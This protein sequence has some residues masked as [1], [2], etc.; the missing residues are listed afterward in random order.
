MSNTSSID[1]IVITDMDNDMDNEF[2]FKNV[3]DFKKFVYKNLCQCLGQCLDLKEKEFIIQEKRTVCNEIINTLG[4]T[5]TDK[6]Y[7][8]YDIIILNSIEFFKKSG[9][10]DNDNIEKKY[11]IINDGIKLK[12]SWANIKSIKNNDTKSL[13]WLFRKL[14]VDIIL[15]KLLLDYTNIK[16]YSVGSTTLSSDYDITVYN[17]NGNDNDNDI[18]HFI[19]DFETMFNNIF[20]DT[21]DIVFDTNIY[22]KSFITFM[23]RENYNLKECDGIKT[24]YY[25]KESDTYNY[26]QLTW[27]LIKYFKNIKESFDEYISED[28]ITFLSKHIRSRNVNLIKIANDTLLTLLNKNLN[29]NILLQNE[30]EFKTIYNNNDPL[31]TETDYISAVNFYG[32][33]TYFTKGA[34]I[35]IVINDQ[36]CKSEGQN[37][38]QLSETDLICSILENTGFYF[39]H[40]N[41][42]KYLKRVI[43]TLNNLI[44]TNPLRYESLTNTTNY[45]EFN[46][47]IKTLKTDDKLDDS[48][49]CIWIDNDKDD[50]DLLK[51]E[52]Y[53]LFNL[54]FH[55]IYILLKINIGGLTIH[56]NRIPFYSYFINKQTNKK[57]LD[58]LQSN[59]NVSSRRSSLDNDI[60]NRTSSLNDNKYHRRSSLDDNYNNLRHSLTTIAENI[61]AEP[62]LK[63]TKEIRNL[64]KIGGGKEIPDWMLPPSKS[65]IMYE[66]LKQYILPNLEIEK[67]RQKAKNEKILLKQKW[68]QEILQQ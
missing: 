2:S 47:I 38:I 55:I 58:L 30:K 33:E 49:Y 29:Y 40:S 5:D 24:F 25:L 53:T 34:F 57:Y 48:K 52:K 36:M 39:V 7:D 26:S 23:K 64:N 35:D 9:L 28:Y 59:S 42:T 31:L 11:Y 43:S 44:S 8:Y 13:F 63:K 56:H 4:D 27:A 6:A 67:K 20:N 62:S 60:L 65:R 3:T 15:K 41:K 17:V 61:A 45:V 16:I 14:I 51:C 37:K 46:N 1:N 54:L 68:E 22:G 21:S 18:S 10:I 32:N 19:N 66:K 50:F 12:L